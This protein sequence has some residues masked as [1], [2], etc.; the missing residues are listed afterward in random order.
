MGYFA[1]GQTKEEAI[2]ALQQADILF[3]EIYERP[4]KQPAGTQH[5]AFDPSQPGRHKEHA[6]L[7]RFVGGYN[8]GDLPTLVNLHEPAAAGAMVGI[9]G[10]LAQC[11]LL[12]VESRRCT[13][14]RLRDASTSIGKL[15]A[16]DS[17]YGPC[18]V[19][20]QPKDSRGVLGDCGPNI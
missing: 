2:R 10:L 6:E 13:S 1:R 17:P 7:P 11:T 18:L 12:A 8:A 19:H 16:S 4:L 14:A 15:L 20:E 5:Q 3:R 9:T